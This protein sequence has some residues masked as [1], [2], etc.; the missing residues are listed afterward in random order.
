MLRSVMVMK[1]H[2]AN[3]PAPASGSHCI[4]CLSWEE[5]E[6]SSGGQN[7]VRCP[8]CGY[9]P[10]RGVLEKSGVKEMRSEKMICVT[11]E[12]HEGAI[13]RQARVTAPSIALALRIAGDGMPGHRVRLVFPIDPEAFFVSG[14]HEHRAVA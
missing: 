11:V 2:P 5:G 6:L 3:P 13:T 8:V 12:I 10:S 7:T 9:A 1:V 4:I 14:S